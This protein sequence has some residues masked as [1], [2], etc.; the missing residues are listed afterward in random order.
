[1]EHNII[2]TRQ[3]HETNCLESLKTFTDSLGFVE[4]AKLSDRKH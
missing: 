1:M 4:S 3:F 2:H